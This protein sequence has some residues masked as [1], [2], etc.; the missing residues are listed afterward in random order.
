[1][2]NITLWQSFVMMMKIEKCQMKMFCYC[3]RKWCRFCWAGWLYWVGR[4]RVV[5]YAGKSVS[6]IL[7]YVQLNRA[8]W[9]DGKKR[10]L[11]LF[12][13]ISSPLGDAEKGTRVVS[14]SW[15]WHGRL[16]GGQ[17]KI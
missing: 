8:G 14:W 15:K 13:K 16:C 12:I 1:M 7:T 6:N 4:R 17:G 2:Y 11:I 3:G 5:W 9:F 10:H